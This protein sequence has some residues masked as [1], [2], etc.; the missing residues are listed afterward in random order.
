MIPQFPF[1]PSQK[2]S[3]SRLNNKYNLSLSLLSNTCR[4]GKINQ[5]E[6]TNNHIQNHTFINDNKQVS[7]VENHIGRKL[8]VT[9]QIIEE[10][11]KEIRPIFTTIVNNIKLSGNKGEYILTI[12]DE[13]S[14]VSENIT[15]EC[16]IIGEKV[17]DDSLSDLVNDVV[18]NKCKDKWIFVPLKQL[19]LQFAD[20]PTCDIRSCWYLT[21]R[22]YYKE[23]TGSYRLS[24]KHLEFFI[25]DRCREYEKYY[26]VERNYQT[27]IEIISSKVISEL[28]NRGDIS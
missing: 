14:N 21:H 22:E 15:L 18:Q 11:I 27:I 26:A 8:E 12:L 1:F 23:F 16:R 7:K 3:S 9:E 5:D 25:C 2:M 4:S 20:D 13:T 19:N 28:K 17:T 6:I 10:L 24:Y